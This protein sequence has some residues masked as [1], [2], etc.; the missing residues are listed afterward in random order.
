M[1]I[2]TVPVE[3]YR[4]AGNQTIKKNDAAK[5]QSDPG[6]IQNITLP[7]INDAE[8][9]SIKAP[10]SPS[11]LSSV[12]TPDEKTMLVGHFARFGDSHESSQIYSTDARVRAGAIIGIKLDVKG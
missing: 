3:A 9:G 7:G 12:L 1:K 5:E 8:A 11:L 2:N 10:A 4:Q 6:R